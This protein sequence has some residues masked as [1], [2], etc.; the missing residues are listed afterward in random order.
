[1]PVNVTGDAHVK[2]CL[3]SSRSNRL[4][5]QEPRSRI[6]CD[7]ADGDVVSRARTYGHNIAP[8]RIDEVSGVATRN[9]HNIELML[10]TCS[11]RDTKRE[12]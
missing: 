10:K 11:I 3:E 7:K 4:P 2:P 5:V 9:S 6:V 1:M 12:K 8:D